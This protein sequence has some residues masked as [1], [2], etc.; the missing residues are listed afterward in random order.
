MG[1][2]CICTNAA[3]KLSFDIS[4]NGIRLEVAPFLTTI[5]GSGTIVEVEQPG[6]VE[7][8]LF[9]FERKRSV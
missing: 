8:C 1:N 7:V 5:L 9:G 6:K 4:E 2:Q 3:I